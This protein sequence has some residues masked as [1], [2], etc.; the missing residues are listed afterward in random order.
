MLAYKTHRKR[1]IID[2]FEFD[3]DFPDTIPKACATKEQIY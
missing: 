3:S 1:A 2:G